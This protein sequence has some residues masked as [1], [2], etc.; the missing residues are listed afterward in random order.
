MDPLVSTPLKERLL[1]HEAGR[2]VG[3]TEQG[4][5]IKGLLVQLLQNSAGGIAQ[6]EPWCMAFIQ[7]C[8]QQVDQLVTDCLD[9]A[10]PKALLP[11]G[12]HC[13]AVW[14]QSQNLR[15]DK[16]KPGSLCVWQLGN[17][18]SGHVGVV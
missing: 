4:G 7:Y 17:T 12:E 9:I 2:W 8:V 6:G 16:P 5:N 10:Q 15:L 13:L 1:I 14:N 18:A 3:I 11:K